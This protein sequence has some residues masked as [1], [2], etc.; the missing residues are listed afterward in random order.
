MLAV[1][2][3]LDSHSEPKPDAV[4]SALKITARVRLDCKSVRA[5]PPGHDEIDVERDADTEEQR[6]GDDVC[7]IELQSRKTAGRHVKSAVR[8]RARSSPAHRRSGAAR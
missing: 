3:W 6:Q 1:P 5:R 8:P 2:G 4:V 7:E